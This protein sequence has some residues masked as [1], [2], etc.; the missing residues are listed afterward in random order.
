MQTIPDKLASLTN[1]TQSTEQ[2]KLNLLGIRE[3]A[4]FSI[5]LVFVQL[6]SIAEID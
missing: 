4:D 3:S 1:Q 2:N 5:G 6:Q